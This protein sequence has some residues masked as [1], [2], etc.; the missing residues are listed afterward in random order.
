MVTIW[1]F[2]RAML[3]G[4][5]NR[6]NQLDATI[7]EAIQSVLGA[8]IGDSEPVNPVQ[9]MLMELFKQ[10]M[11]PKTPNLELLKDD[12]GKFI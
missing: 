7:A 4:L 6:V 8:G 11:Q 5:L 9:L 2:T 3:K 10:H 1:F 12:K